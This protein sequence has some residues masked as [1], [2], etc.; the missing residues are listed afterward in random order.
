MIRPR[1]HRRVSGLTITEMVV[2]MSITTVV[3]A[4]V[5][6]TMQMVRD[7]DM[8]V[9]GLANLHQIGQ[10]VYIFTVDNSNKLPA[11]YFRG[12]RPAEPA[13]SDETDWT[14]LLNDFLAGGGATYAQLENGQRGNELLPM[15]RDPHAT[16]PN[17]GLYHYTAHPVLMPDT[18]EWDPYPVFQFRRPHEV[19]LIADA[20]QR[21]VGRIPRT[22]FATG[23][24]ID[25][26]SLAPNAK[27]FY[28]AGD[29]DNNDLI[30]PGINE[31]P[32]HPSAKN[33]ANIRWRQKNNTAANFVFSDGHCE[34]LR[35]SQVK[36]RNIR[37]D[38]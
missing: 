6:P 20:I 28:D 16:F 27:P 34:V 36:K 25:N 15:F 30:A 3:V 29:S 11:G 8:G 38:P 5:L 26:S 35:M 33:L 32:A 23:F 37:V 24:G 12:S 9:R 14:I 10:A 31:D 19:F 13:S 18:N 17:Q 2:M 7:Q 22:A 21:P 4:A 1:P